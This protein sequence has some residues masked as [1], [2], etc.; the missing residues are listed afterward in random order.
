M[1]DL[2]QFILSIRNSAVRREALA[3]ASNTCNEKCL[4]LGQHKRGGAIHGG[5]ACGPSCI[6]SGRDCDGTT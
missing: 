4:K 1:R 5:R 6:I 3:G 2:E